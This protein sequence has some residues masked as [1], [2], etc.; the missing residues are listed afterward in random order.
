MDESVFPPSVTI[1]K[2]K[3]ATFL[4][5]FDDFKKEL[6]EP[7]KYVNGGIEC[8]HLCILKGREK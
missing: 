7:L 5:N 4:Q 1:G 6:L 8:V 2:E 3:G